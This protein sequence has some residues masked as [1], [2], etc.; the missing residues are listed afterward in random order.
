MADLRYVHL[1]R[2]PRQQIDYAAL[3]ATFFR[4][5]CASLLSGRFSVRP[6]VGIVVS[7]RLAEFVGGYYVPG[8]HA[9]AREAGAQ[10]G[11]VQ[12]REEV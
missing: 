8:F 5:A 10:N 12:V 9:A 2:S 4:H 7:A 1:F 6:R 11:H 3:L